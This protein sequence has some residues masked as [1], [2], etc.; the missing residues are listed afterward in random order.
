MDSDYCLY[1]IGLGAKD[2]VACALDAADL[3]ITL[4][5]DMVEYHP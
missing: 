3:I 4:G 1:T 5:Y 2:L